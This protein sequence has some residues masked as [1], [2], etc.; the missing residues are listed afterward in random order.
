MA[1][2]SKFVQIFFY[3]NLAVIYDLLF[4]IANFNNI[5]NIYFNYAIFV[6]VS[7]VSL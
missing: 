6:I 2:T 7:V 1:N 4:L 3:H 5:Q